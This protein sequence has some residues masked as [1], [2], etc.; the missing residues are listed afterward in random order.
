M[1]YGEI[2]GISNY[3]DKENIEGCFRKNCFIPLHAIYDMKKN[4]ISIHI[5]R[6]EI[7]SDDFT[8]LSIKSLKLLFPFSINEHM[9][10]ES[11]SLKIKR[12]KILSENAMKISLEQYI[13][14]ESYKEYIFKLLYNTVY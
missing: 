8:H 5:R 9:T 2:P 3:N 13:S 6:A 4:F 12:S 14:I 11:N 7:Y 1:S 10:I